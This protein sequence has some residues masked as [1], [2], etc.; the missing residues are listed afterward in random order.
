METVG[1]EEFGQGATLAIEGQKLQ[2]PRKQHLS[3]SKRLRSEPRPHPQCQHVTETLLFGQNQHVPWP[4][5][6]AA[7]RNCQEHLHSWTETFF[8]SSLHI[9]LNEEM[10]AR[11]SLGDKG[12]PGWASSAVH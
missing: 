1:H 6:E 10:W 12:P 2:G 8:P 7:E 9:L 5:P 3:S 4:G 11:R